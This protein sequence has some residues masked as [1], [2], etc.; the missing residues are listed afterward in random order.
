[1]AGAV[2]GLSVAMATSASPTIVVQ[3]DG[4]AGL[5]GT[6]AGAARAP[7]P[8]GALRAVAPGGRVQALAPARLRIL[9]P[10]GGP[11]QTPARLRILV[12][13]GGPLRTPAPVRI[14]I[15]AGGL[16][17]TPARLRLLAPVPGPAEALIPMPRAAQV[18]P[19]RQ[20]V[21]GVAA[22]RSVR[23]R[24]RPGQVRVRLRVPANGRIQVLPGSQV[25]GQLRAVG[26]GQ[27]PAALVPASPAR[28]RIVFRNGTPGQV[29]L[30]IQ[31]PARARIQLPARVRITPALPTPPVW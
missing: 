1:M 18:L 25:P 14:Q 24:V 15:P 4:A 10:A 8:G 5:R 23:L 26:P 21:A 20:M 2:V 12:P 17:Q 19:A 13:A 9:V 22:P 27:R 28:L 31:L 30:R 29:R 3:A 7:L 16:L 6:P 11:F